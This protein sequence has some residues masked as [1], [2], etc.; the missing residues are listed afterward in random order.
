MPMQF[1]NDLTEAET[2]LEGLEGERADIQNRLAEAVED[3]DADLIIRLERRA[4]TVEVELFAARARV[5]KL[6]RLEVE[7]LRREA[8]T[9]RDALEAELSEAT[10]FYGEALTVADEARQ[11][12]QLLQVK[13]YGADSTVETLRQDL[14]DLNDNLKTLVSS[15]INRG[16]KDHEG[17]H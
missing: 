6:R 7:R 14:N 10:K 1:G 2:R 9:R 4:A 3:G 17:I 8:M 16:M 13:A 5:L 12:M 11:K 15:R